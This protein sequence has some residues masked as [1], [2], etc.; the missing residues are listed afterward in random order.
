ALAPSSPALD[1]IPL[2]ACHITVPIRDSSGVPIAQYTITTD[3]RGIK[4]PDNG[5]DKCDIGAYEYVD[6]PT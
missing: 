6:S 5:K 2:D 3:Q 1:Q 4:R